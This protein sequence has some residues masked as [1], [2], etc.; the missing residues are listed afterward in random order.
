[1]TFQPVVPLGGLPGW[2]FLNRT[3]ERQAEVFNAAPV[4]TRDTA[5]FEQNIGNVL[6]ADQLV[7]DRRLLQVALGAFGLEDDI[8]SKAFVRQILEEGSTAD[9]ALANRLADARYTKLTDA[10]GFGEPGLPNTREPGF[11]ARIAAQFRQ[12]EFEIAVGEQDQSLR[13]AMNAQRE[14]GE[15]A[16]ADSSQD[17]RWLRILGTPPLRE[18][19]ETALQ[20]PEGFVNLDLDRQ[21]EIFQDRAARRLGLTDIGQLADEDTRESVIR[22]YLVQDQI[23]SFNVQSSGSI[24]L[25]LLQSAP[26]LF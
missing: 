25:T 22:Q 5:Y 7:S 1:M 9:D 2:A 21:L 16:S 18:V 17:A 23:A 12:R 6:T 3:F 11:G 26:R 20:M 10:F 4:L 8:N 13:L 14:L 24:A 19:F 15:I